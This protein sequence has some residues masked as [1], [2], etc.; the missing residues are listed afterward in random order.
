MDKRRYAELVGI[1]M[2]LSIQVCGKRGTDEKYYCT[3]FQAPAI[4]KTHRNETC[5]I[6]FHTC[7]I[8]F[9]ICY[10]IFHTCCILFTHVASHTPGPI[11][12][13]WGKPTC[14]SGMPDAKNAAFVH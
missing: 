13:H 1:K 12:M 3:K 6:T 2:K 14:S 7:C 8:T 5:C 11:Y 10:I 4:K 9:H